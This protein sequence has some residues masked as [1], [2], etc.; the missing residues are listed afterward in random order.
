MTMYI[1]IPELTSIKG[2][3]YHL[4]ADMC[5]DYIEDCAAGYI[6]NPN[7]DIYDLCAR[8][9]LETLTAEQKTK[10]ADFFNLKF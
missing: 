7:T 6:E 8:Y 2:S 10:L 5:A 1:S 4:A 9:M 3:F